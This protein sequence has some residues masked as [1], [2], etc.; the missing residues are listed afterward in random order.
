MSNSNKRII[1]KAERQAKIKA[2]AE[3]LNNHINEGVNNYVR[4]TYLD[5]KE[6]RKNERWYQAG[7]ALVEAKMQAKFDADMEFNEEFSAWAEKQQSEYYAELDASEAKLLE[8]EDV[9]DVEFKQISL[10]S[11]GRC[12]SKLL[13]SESSPKSLPSSENPKSVEGKSDNPYASKKKP[14]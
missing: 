12:Q 2:N 8:A 7:E 13:S 10:P 11:R 1:T 6:A 14:S 4:E 5:G 9:I 3:K